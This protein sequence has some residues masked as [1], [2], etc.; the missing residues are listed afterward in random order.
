MVSHENE[1]YFLIAEK[2]R[3]SNDT[4]LKRKF[5]LFLQIDQR[6]YFPVTID[7][8][9]RSAGSKQRDH[10]R[11][12]GVLRDQSCLGPIRHDL[13]GLESLF[14][15]V[16]ETELTI[17]NEIPILLFEKQRLPDPPERSRILGINIRGNRNQMSLRFCFRQH[18]GKSIQTIETGRFAVR[19]N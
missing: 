7:H 13:Q 6:R 9:I 19:T 3:E 16:I 15:N 10:G 12:T 1:T 5:A 2:L 17:F 18:L 14:V 8:E 11:I 4:V